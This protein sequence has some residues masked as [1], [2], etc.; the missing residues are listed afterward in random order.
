MVD[1]P[2]SGSGAWRRTPAQ[3]WQI[4]EERLKE[5]IQLQKTIMRQATQLVSVG[6]RLI[7]ATCSILPNENEEQITWFLQK[8]PNFKVLPIAKIWPKA[9]GT[10]C[11]QSALS[12]DTYL[13]LTPA[14]HDTDG[15][16]AAVLEKTHNDS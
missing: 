14:R 16:F 9:F 2:C 4:T 10:K 3:K 12:C 11:P 7:Y 1:V 13:S 5:L 15:F 6:G 8:Y